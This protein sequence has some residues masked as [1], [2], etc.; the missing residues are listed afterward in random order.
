MKSDIYAANGKLKQATEE[1][2]INKVEKN[3]NE[4]ILNRGIIQWDNLTYVNRMIQ[5]LS[6]E[7]LKIVLKSKRNFF[8]Q[9][10]KEQIEK[11]CVILKKIVDEGY[12][13]VLEVNQINTAYR[14]LAICYAFLENERELIFKYLDKALF[15]YAD[16][17]SIDGIIGVYIYRTVSNL[18]LYT[19]NYK[20]QLLENAI[21]NFEMVKNYVFAIRMKK[22]YK[23]IYKLELLI[24]VYKCIDL[25][26]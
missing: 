19:K 16:V 18:I 22:Y 8:L 13:I 20:L 26:S 10:E 3:V 12:D 5:F 17:S 21:T 23:T 14:S 6:T 15:N 24:I 7:Y 1:I 9:R 2:N 4:I 11:C 25:I